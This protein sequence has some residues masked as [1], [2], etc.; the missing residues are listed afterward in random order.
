[1]DQ[2][3]RGANKTTKNTPP[4]KNTPWCETLSEKNWPISLK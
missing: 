2:P 3:Q 4:P 1:M